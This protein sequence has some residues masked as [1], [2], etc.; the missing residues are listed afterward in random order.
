[1]LLPILVAF[2][3]VFVVFGI[4]IA[5]RLR[6]PTCR[7]CLFRSACPNRELEYLYPFEETLLESR[8][9]Q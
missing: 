1:M 2:A 8:T 6:K 3:V 7:I 4:V 9:E 5:R